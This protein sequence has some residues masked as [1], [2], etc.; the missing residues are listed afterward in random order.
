[1]IASRP[2]DYTTLAPSVRSQRAEQGIFITIKLANSGAAQGPPTPVSPSVML[3]EV[4]HLR[5]DVQAAQNAS[6]INGQEGE[7]HIDECWGSRG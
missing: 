4:Q 5:N 7:L 3:Y 6:L 2:S 1:M